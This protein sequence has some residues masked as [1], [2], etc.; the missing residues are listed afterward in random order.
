MIT[1]EKILELES[2]MTVCIFLSTLQFL[3]YQNHN[4]RLDYHYD[5]RRE[6]RFRDKPHRRRSRDENIKESPN[7][8]LDI[9]VGP[10]KKPVVKRDGV[11]LTDIEDD[12][13]M[14]N[15]KDSRE[16]GKLYMLSV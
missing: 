11:A 10:G 12:S 4:S 5:Y 2:I 15:P 9:E 13:R 7:V 16:F 14:P 3:C 6:N 1:V 8:H